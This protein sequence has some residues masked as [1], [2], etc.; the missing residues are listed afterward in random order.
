MTTATLNRGP[1]ETWCGNTRRQHPLQSIMPGLPLCHATQALRRQGPWLNS[2]SN[3]STVSDVVATD[4]NAEV[5]QQLECELRGEHKR[6][7]R[8]PEDSGRT[9]TGFQVCDGDSD[10][11]DAV[12][13]LR[14]KA[15]KISDQRNSEAAVAVA[16]A[17]A[18]E[19][20]VAAAATAAATDD[21]DV[22]S[23]L[24]GGAQ[25]S[26]ST[27]PPRVGTERSEHT[28]TQEAATYSEAGD[29][30]D[31]EQDQAQEAASDSEADDCADEPHDAALA[32]RKASVRFVR[33]MTG[34]F[35]LPAATISAF[36]AILQV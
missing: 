10:A 30:T 32:Q 29:C 35:K 9:W 18:T 6:Y 33:R 14:N 25:E 31:S 20:V 4:T 28:Q 8:D 22:A 19:A 7:C 17:A 13:R 12:T 5:E 34:E 16:A 1:F 21:V 11:P 24:P 15:R 26:S 27:P 2:E 23:E 3:S 36:V